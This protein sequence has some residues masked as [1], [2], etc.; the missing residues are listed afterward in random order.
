MMAWW[1]VRQP[2]GRYARYSDV[3]GAFTHHSMTAEQAVE[4]CCGHMTRADARSAV[5][6]SDEPTRWDGCLK[7]IR[8][9]YGRTRLTSILGEMREK[10]PEWLVAEGGEQDG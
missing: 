6:R 8:K 2:N 10:L 5:A 7:V 3:A 4:Y 1:I 9:V